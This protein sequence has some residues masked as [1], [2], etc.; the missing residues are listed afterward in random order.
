MDSPK[1]A[2]YKRILF[3][4]ERRPIPAKFANNE[5]GIIA[6]LKALRGTSVIF[7]NNPGNIG[8]YL[9]EE[10]TRQVF[11][12]FQINYRYYEPDI[13]LEDEI[14]FLG[15][16][17][18]LVP[19]YPEIDRLYTNILQKNPKK[20]ILL[21]H[22]VKG[23]LN[24]LSLIRPQD[25]IFARENSTLN[26]LKSKNLQC[27]IGIDHDIAFLF[28]SDT[29]LS[30]ENVLSFM[31]L[32]GSLDLENFR[33]PPSS[34]ENFGFFMR[35]DIEA[36]AE[37]FYS[38]QDISNNIKFL[39]SKEDRLI[40]LF[41]FMLTLQRTTLILTDRLHVAIG[42]SILGDG[43]KVILFD[44]SYG[45]NREVYNYSMQDCS[46]TLFYKQFID[47][48]FS[49]LIR[50]SDNALRDSD[51]ALHERDNAL[52]ERDNALHERDNVLHSRI[53]RLTKPLR[54]VLKRIK[55]LEI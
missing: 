53:W 49:D 43:E 38:A 18:G 48:D 44:N 5:N 9:I 30:E 31:D 47:F 4:P 23:D 6:T 8:D 27:Q 39:E 14:V 33:Y 3:S 32:L 28:D 16:G 22:T 15:G 17:G 20:I 25:Y 54:V 10:E 55:K 45:K 34:K 46:G 52:H 1:V 51:N 19:L 13:S 24:F 35:K 21:P 7:Q 12:R 50:D 40:R 41:S 29:F 2:F 42:K 37:V 11:K 36:G 26:F